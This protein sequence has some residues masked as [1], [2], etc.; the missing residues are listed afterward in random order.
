[1][2]KKTCEEQRQKRSGMWGLRAHR[3]MGKVSGDHTEQR[4]PKNAHQGV[5]ICV[6]TQPFTFPQLSFL[7]GK[8]PLLP[9]SPTIIY[10]IVPSQDMSEGHPLRS[11]PASLAKCR[12]QLQGGLLSS[13]C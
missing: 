12:V 1:M 3:W 4:T 2:K 9:L 13:P 8:N 11:C 10:L 5:N 6:T 7:L